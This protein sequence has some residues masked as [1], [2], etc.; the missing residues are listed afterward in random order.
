MDPIKEAMIRHE[1][2]NGETIKTYAGSDVSVS[3]CLVTLESFIGDMDNAEL[4]DDS[5]IDTANAVTA[6]NGL[7]WSMER[8]EA[9]IERLLADADPPVCRLQF[10]DGHVP[11]NAREAAEGWH[12]WYN[13]KASNDIKGAHE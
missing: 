10:P 1:D 4:A 7:I 2:E 5:T 8:R 11:G 12:R 6:I 13:A 9:M 3:Q